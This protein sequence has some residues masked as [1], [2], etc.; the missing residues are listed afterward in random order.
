M[1]LKRWH[2]ILDIDLPY[3][4]SPF[5]AVS[6]VRHLLESNDASNL[7][8][9]RLSEDSGL[10]YMNDKEHLYRC[11]LQDIE[12]GRLCLILD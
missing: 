8:L 10:S 7:D 2:S 3:L 9:G 1:P 11:I 6:K 5:F 12:Y 4:E